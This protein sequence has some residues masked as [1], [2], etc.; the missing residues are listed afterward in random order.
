MSQWFVIIHFKHFMINLK[1]NTCDTP[2]S[3]DEVL[4]KI[5][6]SV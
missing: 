3:K 6:L 5:G 2:Q 1:V 4:N